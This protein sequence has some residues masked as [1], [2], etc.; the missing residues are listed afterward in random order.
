MGLGDIELAVGAEGQNGVLKLFARVSKEVLAI[1]GAGYGANLS[2][3]LSGLSF[4][5]LLPIGK[6]TAL[7]NFAYGEVLQ[8][9]TIRQNSRLL[10]TGYARDFNFHGN[11]YY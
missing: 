6:M 7:H 2:C 5:H 11:E 3:E 4:A 9:T 1:L 10:G 8:L